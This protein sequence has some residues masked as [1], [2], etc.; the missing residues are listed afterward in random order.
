MA[1]LILGLVLWT[2]VHLFRRAAP[3]MRG[4][5]DAA[6]GVR[7]AK[8]LA[9]GLLAVALILI[10]LGYRSAD[11]LSVYTPQPGIGHWV[12]FLMLAALFVFGI[13][14]VGGPLSARIRHPMLWG[15]ILWSAAHLL[16]N[17]DLASIVLFGG[18]GFWAALQIYSVNLHEGPWEVPMPGDAV[19]DWKLGLVAL[20]LFLVIGGIH[21]LFDHNPF[22]GTFL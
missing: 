7:G 1:L 18:L 15:T 13:G 19:Q 10:V 20:F 17:G 14:V 22:V 2:V 3:A 11:F 4:D 16:V 21:W 8:L 12:N 9:A 6:L 5:L